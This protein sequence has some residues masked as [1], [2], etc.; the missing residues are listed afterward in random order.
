[1]SDLEITYTVHADLDTNPVRGNACFSGDTDFD[2]AVET[3]IINR[4]DR[5]DIWA[6]AYVTVK[7]RVEFN[8]F[9]CEGEAGLGCCSYENQEEF[10]NDSYF[11][12]LKREAKRALVSELGIIAAQGTMAEEALHGL[13]CIRGLGGKRC[14]V[15]NRP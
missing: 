6:W 15:R 2:R 3:G 4:L 8:G 12:D 10:E 1:M 14:R 5:G 13:G 7:A 9:I 11:E